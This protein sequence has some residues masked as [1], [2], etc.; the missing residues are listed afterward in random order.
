M[1]FFNIIHS[2]KKKAHKKLQNDNKN[3]LK[4]FLVCNMNLFRHITRRIKIINKQ[5]NLSSKGTKN[6]RNPALIS[7]IR[8]A[9]FTRL[10]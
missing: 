2:A 5:S 6:I 7:C 8:L 9:V 4:P 1:N 10:A 3:V